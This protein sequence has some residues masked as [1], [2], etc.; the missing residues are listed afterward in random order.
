MEPNKFVTV[1]LYEAASLSETLA[2]E[3][4]A[5]FAPEMLAPLVRTT[6]FFRQINVCGWLPV[7]T[8]ENWAVLP[9]R[10]VVAVGSLVNVGAVPLAV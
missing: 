4:T 1:T 6:L 2:T 10:I 5:D 9:A 8:T 3:S 7:V